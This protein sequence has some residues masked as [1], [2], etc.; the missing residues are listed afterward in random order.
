MWNRLPFK[1]L[2]VRRGILPHI[3]TNCD[4]CNNVSKDLNHVLVE[5]AYAVH[6]WNLLSNRLNL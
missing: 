1:V 3:L 5:C 6:C 2:L 4:L